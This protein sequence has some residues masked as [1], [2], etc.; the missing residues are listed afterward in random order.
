VGGA[1]P[2]YQRAKVEHERWITRV[3]RQLAAV[4]APSS[5]AGSSI[6]GQD[7]RARLVILPRTGQPRTVDAPDG[8]WLDESPPGEVVVAWRTPGLIPLDPHEENIIGPHSDRNPLW[9]ASLT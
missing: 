5:A 9:A 6:A 2:Q 7:V 3:R 4:G 8:I 1:P